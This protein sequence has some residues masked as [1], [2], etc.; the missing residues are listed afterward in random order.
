MS[1]RVGYK[2]SAEQFGPRELVDYAV[3]RTRRWAHHAYSPLSRADATG[4]VLENR[5]RARLTKSA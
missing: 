5:L 3:N 4:V 1:L 2:A